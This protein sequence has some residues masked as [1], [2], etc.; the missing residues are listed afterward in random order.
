MK[1]YYTCNSICHKCKAS[2]LPGEHL[3]LNLDHWWQIFVSTTPKIYIYAA[4]ITKRF[5]YIYIYYMC[6]FLL[7]TTLRYTRLRD[8]PNFQR[9]SVADFYTQCVK[10]I[11][12]LALVTGFRPERIRFCLMHSVHLGICQWLNG[13]VIHELNDHKYFGEG[14]LHEQLHNLTRRF[15]AWCSM[16]RIRL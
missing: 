1:K 16:N 15:N 13:S 10:Q 7:Q 6:V 5:I 2:R 8:F 11:C 4:Y 9:F 14:L 3:Q 12:P